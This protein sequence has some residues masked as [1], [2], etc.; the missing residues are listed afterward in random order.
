[1]KTPVNGKVEQNTTS[2]SQSRAAEFRPHVTKP[3]EHRHER[4][5]LREQL[6]R[7]D[8]LQGAEDEVFA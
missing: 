1:M 8:W 5:R 7:L 3:R 6:R 2:G 4:R